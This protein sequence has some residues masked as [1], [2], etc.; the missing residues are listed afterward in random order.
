MSSYARITTEDGDFN[1]VCEISEAGAMVAFG[2]I[3][4]D[5]ENVPGE[6][7]YTVTDE[8]ADEVAQFIVNARWARVALAGRREPEAG[9]GPGYPGPCPEGMDW[10]AWLAFNNVD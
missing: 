6:H 2:L 4:Y 7:C 5:G 10:S 9:A 3:T 8:N 1:E